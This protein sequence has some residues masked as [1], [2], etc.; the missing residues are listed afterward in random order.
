MPAHASTS[1]A[2]IQIKEEGVQETPRKRRIVEISGAADDLTD[3]EIRLELRKVE[4]QLA[5]CRRERA[6]ASSENTSSDVVK[7][8]QSE[9]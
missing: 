8:E 9:V 6:K 1:V 4:L 7:Q 3:E 2:S 5:L